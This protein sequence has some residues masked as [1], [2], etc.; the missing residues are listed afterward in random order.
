MRINPTM[1]QKEETYQ[2]VLDIIKN[3]TF[4]KAFLASADVPEIYMQQF[5]HTVTKIKES[6]FYKF[7][8]ANKKCL[9]DVEVFRQA[10][11]ICLRVPRKEFVVP[12]SEEELLT[13]LIGYRYKGELAH[14]PQMFIDHMHQP[15]RTL[16][17]II[18][19][20]LSG[21]TT[22]N[23]RLRQSKVS[24]I[25][26]MFHKKYVDYAELIWEDFSYQIDNRQLKKSRHEIMPYPRFTKV[27]INHFLSIYK[28]L[29]KALPS[30]LHTI[31]DDDVL[32]R[33]KF[34]RIGED[35]QEY[36]RAI[37]VA[38]L[39]NDIKGKG[40]QGK[41][42]AV[43]PKPVSVEVSDEF[44]YE[45]ARKWV[46]NESTFTLT[47]SSKGTGTKLGVLDEENV[48]SKAKDDVY[49]DKEE[50]KK[51]ND[52]DDKSID[53]EETGDEETDDEF[54]REITDTAKADAEKTEEVKD[55]TKKAELPPSSSS[56]SSLSILTVPILV[57]S[58]LAALSQIPKIPLVTSTTTPPPPHY[59][60]TISHVLQQTTTPI[61][62]PPI[63]TVAPP[64]TMILD[65]LPVI[66]QRVFVQ[67]KDVQE[68]K[69]VDHTTTHLDSLRSEIPLVVN[70][71]LG[72]SLGDAL[73]KEAIEEAVQANVINEVK[74]LLRKFLLKAVYNFATSMIQSIVKK[75]LEKTLIV[76]DKSYFYLMHDKHQAL[77]DALLNSICLDDIVAQGQADTEKIMRKRDHGDDRDKDPSVGPNQGKKTNR[78]RTKESELP[79][80]TSTTKETSKG[81]AP[82]KG[83]KSNKSV[84]AEESVAEPTEEVIMDALNDD[85]VNDNDQTQSD[86]KP[87]H[88]WFTQPPRP[89][90]SDL[91]WNK[92][93]VVDD[94][95][96]H[97]WF[98]DLLY[99]E[100][101]PLTFNELIATPID[102]YKFEMNRLKI[103]KRTKAHLV[104]PD[105][106]LLKGIC[107]SSIDLEY[108]M[109]E[110]YK[111]LSDQL[112]WNNPEGDRCPFD[113]SK[114]LPLKGRPGCLT[115]ASEYFFNNDLEYLKSSDPEKK[116]TMPITKTKAK[117]YELVD[118]EQGI[119]HWGPKR[120][121]FYKSQINI[122]S[123]HHVY[124]TQKILSVVRRAD[125]QL[126]TF[127]EGAF[128][129]LHLND[130]E[131]MLFLAAQHKLFQLD[132]SDIV[133]LV[134]AL[135]MFTRSLIIKRRV[136]DVQFGVESYQKKLNITKPKKEFLV[137]SAKELYTQSF[138]LPGVVYEELN[139]KK[140]VMWADELY[141]F[142]DGTLKLVLDK[143]HHRILNF[144]LGFN[145]EMS[146]RKWSATDKRR[147]K[148][149]VEL[150][151]KQ[152]QERRILRNLERLVGA[153]EL[154]IDYMLM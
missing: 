26:G 17:S 120:Q 103:E 45:P 90:T 126:Y 148:L 59:V 30:G 134:V 23:D 84:H 8:L 15:W 47:T 145:K 107:Q 43:S 50:E 27:I 122:F 49:F 100:K 41:K 75:A 63:T 53:I 140:K 136:E 127:K 132:G 74:N 113:L 34:V 6:T 95:Q 109:E 96:E 105:Y 46:P 3:T 98:N 147:S 64:V 61:P 112:D 56:L 39:T 16:E 2:V 66:I 139:N 131:D 1:T 81:N 87:K 51:D 86:P 14:L 22:S 24:I 67:E 38:M 135:R 143:L 151:D 129:D 80:K 141:K 42:T 142:S 20:C 11:D 104:G 106:N 31:K 68:L 85:V 83:S 4:Y 154:E 33:M 21:K 94:S 29:P 57:I 121:L 119:K 118:A 99:A 88:N 13:I 101:G 36:G 69:E 133:D 124:S 152:M 65:L 128:V 55:D 130:N 77:F 37:P 144:L 73:Q 93:K 48:T 10:L 52:E 44:D 18:N 137:I 5:W 76:I 92:G 91:E 62:S 115:V 125:R 70:S 114:P 108:N 19:K 153:R 32:S 7:K 117:I 28:S 60:S 82:T 58:E 9:V 123:K 97:I 89:P 72:S 40:S 111:V 12:P 78:R 149:M 25:W 146:R 116:Y 110:C 102:F 138:D 71:Y 54:V 150:I 35:I 79:K